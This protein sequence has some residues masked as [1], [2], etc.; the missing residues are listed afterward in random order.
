MDD[1]S[2]YPADAPKTDLSGF[3]AERRGDRRQGPG[4]GG[5]LRRPDKIVDQL[6]QLKIPVYVA[7]A[8]ATLDD[9]YRQIT[10][11][12]TLTGHADR[13]RRRWSSG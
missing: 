12:G 1:Y 7:P 11:L 10:E 4:P 8:A 3:T 2:N 9:T 5:A 6:E 13:G